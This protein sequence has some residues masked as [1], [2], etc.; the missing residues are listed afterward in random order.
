MRFVSQL[1]VF[2]LLW[3]GR[4]LFSYN[5]RWGLVQ[6][7]GL[8]IALSYVHHVDCAYINSSEKVDDSCSWSARSILQLLRQLIEGPVSIGQ[9]PGRTFET[10]MI[11][12]LEKMW[13]SESTQFAWMRQISQLTGKAEVTF[14]EHFTSGNQQQ[15]MAA[16][17]PIHQTAPHSLTYLQGMIK[18]ITIV[19]HGFT[20]LVVLCGG[21]PFTL[22]SQIQVHKLLLSVQKGSI[23]S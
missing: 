19:E 7:T 20:F 5:S 10:C 4:V 6:V 22:K 2:R 11:Y 15:A 8:F 14:A 17:R 9:R 13:T 23:R 21:I 1:W 18:M 12:E 3:S 16:L